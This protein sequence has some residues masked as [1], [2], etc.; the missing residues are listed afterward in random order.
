MWPPHTHTHARPYRAAH[1][2]TGPDTNGEISS[3]TAA[4]QDDSF[5][6]N[7]VLRVKYLA[8]SLS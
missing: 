1:E 8:A 7:S 2:Q 4:Y 3:A 6:T 5:T